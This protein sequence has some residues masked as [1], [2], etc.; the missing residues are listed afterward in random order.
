MAAWKVTELVLKARLPDTIPHRPGAKLVLLVLTGHCGR[1]GRHAFPSIATI[2]AETG[3]KSPTTVRA[4]LVAL[5]K[6]RLIHV[7]TAP[8]QWYPTV[9]RLDLTEIGKL[10]PADPRRSNSD[11]L[12]TDEADVPDGQF[13][14]PD[15]QILHARRSNSDSKQIERTDL[16]RRTRTLAPAPSLTNPR[17]A[18]EPNGTNFAPIRRLAIDLLER[19]VPCPQSRARPAP[20]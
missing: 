2:C 5:C 20:R 10:I 1:D 8:A 15:R 4:H 19:G 12:S 14:T 18:S 16:N 13:L 6:H 7:E 11:G 17:P 9:Y 3:I